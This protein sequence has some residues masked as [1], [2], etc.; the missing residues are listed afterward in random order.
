M[1]EE[2]SV[3]SLVGSAADLSGVACADEGER[4]GFEL[5]LVIGGEAAC[6]F[7]VGGF[8]VNFVGAFDGVAKLVLKARLDES[9]GEVGNVDAD[10]ATVESLRGGDGGAAPAEGIEN[11]VAFVGAGLEQTFQ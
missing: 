4:P 11:Y 8:A 5:E 6:A 7:E 2:A 9:D 1:E 10:P 3:D